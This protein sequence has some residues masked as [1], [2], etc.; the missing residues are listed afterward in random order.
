MIQT[1]IL[2]IIC[3]AR[4][5]TGHSNGHRTTIRTH[6]WRAG[7]AAVRAGMD[8]AARGRVMSTGDF[9][10]EYVYKSTLRD[11]YGLTPAMIRELGDPDKLTKNPHWK[12]GPLASLYLIERV[13]A[14]IDANI[15]R[16]EQAREKRVKRAA[17]AK[18]ANE[19]KYTK[20]TQWAQMVD[21]TFTPPTDYDAAWDQAEQHYLYQSTWDDY[22]TISYNGV[23]AYIR[24][25]CTNYDR[26]LR[27]IDGKV[28]TYQAYNIIRARVDD[29]VEAWL[30]DART[31]VADDRPG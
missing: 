3:A 26:L 29:M 2:C 22:R 25:N 27:Q 9:Q 19:T 30:N 28:G 11:V 1:A 12:S 5:N 23:V 15:E 17:S 13:E 20:I 24:H 18:R 4:A 8:R 7:A 10:K 14:W 31:E 16:V 6:N 21:I